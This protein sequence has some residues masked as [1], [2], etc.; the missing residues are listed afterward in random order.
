M[1]LF[2]HHTRIVNY[3]GAYAIQ[4][5]RLFFFWVYYKVAPIT[6][7]GGNPYVKTYPTLIAAQEAIVASYREEKKIREQKAQNGTVVVKIFDNKP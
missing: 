1:G 6:L 5:R 7:I 3:N 4:N 2:K